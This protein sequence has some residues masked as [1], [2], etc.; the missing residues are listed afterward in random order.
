MRRGSYMYKERGVCDIVRRGGYK[1]G[2]W[3]CEE[4]GLQGGSVGL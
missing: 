4:G 1:E 2:V 3:G